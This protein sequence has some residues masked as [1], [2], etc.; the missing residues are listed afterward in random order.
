[1]PINITWLINFHLFSLE[2]LCLH[3]LSYILARQLDNIDSK[4]QKFQTSHETN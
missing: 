2:Y 4:H 3:H 1:M